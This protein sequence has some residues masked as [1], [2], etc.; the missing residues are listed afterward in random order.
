MLNTDLSQE[1]TVFEEGS[2]ILLI[3]VSPPRRTVAHNKSCWIEV[4]CSSSRGKVVLCVLEYIENESRSTNAGDKKCGVYFLQWYFKNYEFPLCWHSGKFQRVLCQSG[5]HI[6]PVPKV[7]S[8]LAAFCCFR[9]RL[10]TSVPVAPTPQLLH[11]EALPLLALAQTWP[12]PGRR[13]RR[14]CSLP[15]LGELPFSLTIL[16]CF[17]KPF[18]FLKP[19]P[20]LGLWLFSRQKPGMLPGSFCISSCCSPP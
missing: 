19:N 7:P 6:A 9:E 2:S 17:S 15:Q 13:T 3:A 10:K 12:R 5:H 18:C 11:L 8:C 20:P 1:C 4:R 16:A 14:T